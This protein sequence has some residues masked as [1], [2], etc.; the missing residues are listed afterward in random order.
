MYVHELLKPTTYYIM[1]FPY[2]L[3]VA[4]RVPVRV[5][6]PGRQ[7]RPKGRCFSLFHEACQWELLSLISLV[8]NFK[9]FVKTK[10]K[11]N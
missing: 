11:Q 7:I 9:A 6:S 10:T 4:V 5:G 8:L 1:N 3:I 2:A